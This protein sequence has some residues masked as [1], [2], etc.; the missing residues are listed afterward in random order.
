MP[1]LLCSVPH[2]WQRDGGPLY[3]LVS[4]RL[5]LGEHPDCHFDPSTPRGCRLAPYFYLARGPRCRPVL[6][7]SHWPAPHGS[8]CGGLDPPPSL[9]L[10]V[11]LSESVSESVRSCQGGCSSHL[12]RHPRLSVNSLL[13]SVLVCHLHSWHQYH[14]LN[15]VGIYLQL[16]NNYP[17]IVVPRCVASYTPMPL[18][19]AFGHRVR[20]P[21]TQSLCSA[22]VWASRVKD[23]Q[24]P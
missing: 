21:F 6:A 19:E 14:F 9:P 23:L 17:I 22:R 16:K 24:K 20:T 10:C 11:I 15:N 2:V 4:P 3:P 7:G 1:L 12:H 8:D 13:T 18:Y 5:C